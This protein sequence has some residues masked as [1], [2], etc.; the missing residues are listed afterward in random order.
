MSRVGFNAKALAPQPSGLVR[1]RLLQLTSARVVMVVA[2]AGHGKTTFLAQAAA[3][4]DGPVA[5]YRFDAYDRPSGAFGARVLPS[6]LACL[7]PGHGGSGVPAPGH[8]GSDPGPSRVRGAG[9]RTATGP[10]DPVTDL[11]E[12]VAS[13]LGDRRGLLVLDDFHEISGSGTEHS[14]LRVMERAPACLTTVVAGRRL[15]GLP[16]PLLRL[17]SGV[18][19]VDADALRFRSWEVESLF[20]EVYRVPLH[21]QDAAA[22]TV[23]TGGWAAGLAMFHLLTAGRPPADRRAALEGLN[24]GMRV[25]RAYLVREVLG[26]LPP[27]LRDFLRRT[28]VL[29]VLTG[30]LCDE[31]LARTGS[32]AV[33]EDL[34][35]RQLFTAAEDDGL[36]FRYHQ[37]LQDHL[38]LELRERMGPA[39]AR[40]WHA[41]AARILQ[42]AGESREAFRACVLAGDWEGAEQLLRAHGREVVADPLGDLA[43]L[44][45]EELAEH[46]PWL[47]LASARRQMAHGA[48]RR[49]LRTYRR[50]E[51]LA[52][53]PGV[54]DLCRAERRRAAVWAPAADPAPRDW[55]GAIRAG[56]TGSPVRAQQAARRL[57]GPA[58]Y[59][60]TG[61]LALLAGDPT[62]AQHLLTRAAAHPSAGPDT[63]RV[64]GLGRA[65]A[66]VLDPEGCPEP[67]ARLLEAVLPDA[68]LTGNAFQSR[69]ARALVAAGSD[70]GTRLELLVEEADRDGDEWGGALVR[71]LHALARN[72]REPAELA[73]ERFRS[74]QAPVL[75]YWA[76]CL[77]GE[78]TTASPGPHGPGPADPAGNGPDPSV[79]AVPPT[80]SEGRALG[81]RNGPGRARSWLLA[82]TG[83]SRAAGLRR[84]GVPGTG[85]GA[86]ED[87]PYPHVGAPGPVGPG[88]GPRHG[89]VPAATVA[90]DVAAPGTARGGTPAGGGAEPATRVVLLGGFSMVAAG[91]VVDVARVRPRVRTVLRFLALHAG[92]PVH[93]DTLLGSLWPDT[94]PE[95]GL[96]SVQVAVSALR[97]L[98]EPDAPRGRST[99]LTR[100]GDAYQLELPPGGSCDLLE[101]QGWLARAERSRVARDTAAEAHALR[102]A[103]AEYRGDLLPE[104]GTAEWVLPERDRFRLLAADAAE[105]LARV[106]MIPDPAGGHGEGAW[107]ESLQAARRCLHLDPY[108]DGAW[109]LLIDLHER[110][111]DLTAAQAAR[112]QRRRVLAE[113]GLTSTE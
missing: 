65:A 105:R 22:L 75:G 87:H 63:L 69:L 49:A 81:I 103:L 90:R 14:L 54:A 31:L 20:R 102:R 58:G 51:E 96:R 62:G 32:Q 71:L 37:V 55:R 26:D 23:R 47:V 38:E 52:A 70:D 101:L 28:S 92:R 30:D 41:R 2:P 13:A 76:R 84:P 111:G 113:L 112:L 53:D 88:T 43:G 33:L 48:V 36:R 79:T 34:E 67:P 104:E 72:D 8:A 10:G 106:L 78:V 100:L 21:P 46:D 4:F 59:L 94:G 11:V 39:A 97:H 86:P 7:G 74:L 19:V 110:V 73:E 16:L 108:R 35:Q 5:W 9:P 109:R 56:T 64:A 66:A 83:A 1:E 24:R 45:P 60:A 44:L 27:Q 77:A 40:G 93:R 50:A 80:E 61:V 89:P 91:T 95:A 17:V 29:G 99:F 3:A 25:V 15:P 85:G 68:D 12:G 42:A 82:R 98:L 107:R 57:P 6:I 18:A